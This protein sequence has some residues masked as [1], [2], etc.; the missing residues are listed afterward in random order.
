MQK[1]LSIQIC[2]RL[3]NWLGDVVMSLGFL[4]L[5]TQTYPNASVTVIVKKGLEQ[6][7]SDFPHVNDIIVFSKAEHKG[8]AGA[9]RFGRQ[10]KAKEKF[11][12]FFVLPD[13]FSAAVMAFATGAKQRV[14]YGKEGRNFL[15]TNAYRK[16]K[17][18]HRVEEYAYLLRFFNPASAQYKLFVQLPASTKK[19][20]A[21]LVVNI[22]SE[23][24]SR[25]L[26]VEKAVALISLLQQYQ[27]PVKLIGSQKERS[28]V[29]DVVKRLPI[30]DGIEILAGETN[31]QQL[32]TLIQNATLM[33]S[34]DSGPAHLA[35]AS[36]VPLVVL[37]GAGDESN[38]GP[39]KN[40]KAIV[41]RNGTLPCEPCVKNT[42]KLASLP[43]CMRQLDLNKVAV[44]V[45]V[46]LKKN[47]ETC[48]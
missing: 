5:L 4:H 44:A 12:L 15:L 32:I 3:P 38:T 7:V 29:N 34:S 35:G 26:P 20:N 31:L 8:L 41:V 11:D 13:S 36:K 1:N 48:F 28:Y 27:L 37:F 10:L 40:N 33:V 24:V 25:R 2:V 16:R 6:L 43:V 18:L 47:D 21:Y 23:A 19:W 17:S 9:W 30:K 22:N 39:Y 46:L 42:C 14:G 45:D